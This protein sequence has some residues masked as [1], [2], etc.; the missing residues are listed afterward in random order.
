[1]SEAV[2]QAARLL[3][4]SQHVAVLT[5]AGV[6][7]ESGVPTFRDAMEGLW[8]QYDP[9]QLATPHAFRANPKLVWDWYEWRRSMVRKAQPNPGHFALA[10]LE[11]RLRLTLIT[12]NVDD[13]H[14]QAGS[15]AII[16]LH[17]NIAQSKCFFDCQGDPTLIDLS[18]LEWD[19]ENGPPA[20]PHCGR[21]VRPDVVWFGDLLP[22]KAHQAA[23]E[24]CL[25]CDVMLVVGTSGLVSPAAEMPLLAKRGGA[26]IIEVNPD[27]TMITRI[28][29]V[30][31]GGP[32]GVMLPQVV[33]ALDV[34]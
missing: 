29:D 23:L 3:K 21:W 31:L 16:H 2:G 34:V 5:G 9:Q 33:E 11:K 1:M 25:D 12:Q 13:L 18:T 24:A 17:G 8:A 20:C 27:D 14:E 30:K 26:K 32:S 10:E 19:A 6:S 7:K 28:A 4:V 15:Q 22:P